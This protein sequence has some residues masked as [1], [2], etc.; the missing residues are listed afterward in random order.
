LET[1]VRKVDDLTVEFTQMAPS[2]LFPLILT[3]P[4]EFIFDSVEMKAHATA[5]DPWS[6]QFTDAEGSAAFG[7]YCLT[8]WTAGESMTIE[9]NP[10]YYRE[11]PYFTKVII[12]KVAENANRVAAIKTGEADVVIGLSPS[13][14]EELR[15]DPD[16]DVIGWYSNE[17]VNLTMNDNFEPWSLPNNALLR[18]AVAYAIPYDTI[19]DEVFYGGATRYYSNVPPGYVDQQDFPI[20]EQDL[21][22]ARD[23]LA[24]AGFPN[25]E[26]LDQYPGGLELTYMVERKSVMEPLALRMQTALAEVG[27]PITLNP[28]STSEFTSRIMTVRDV[29]FSLDDHEHPIGPDAA[30]AISLYFRSP[31]AGGISNSTNYSNPMVDEQVNAALGMPLGSE[32][33]Q[34]LADLQEFLMQELPWA[35]VVIRKSEIAVRSGIV[36]WLGCP[37]TTVDWYTFRMDN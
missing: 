11:Q 14:Y 20:Y 34:A 17:A 32:R 10:N 16:I 18:Q 8:E 22:K 15:A 25:G 1:E 27:I 3:I 37:D 28:I 2:A 21:D 29:A 12:R 31:E 23:L 7:P 19:I 4:Y 9:A 33:T 36:G 35:P 26:G 13:E 24:Q 30:Y 5:E 6:H